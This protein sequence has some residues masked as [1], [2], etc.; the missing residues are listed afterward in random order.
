M[1]DESKAEFPGTL[2]PEAC[3][4]NVTLHGI[5]KSYPSWKRL[6]PAFM[7]SRSAARQASATLASQVIRYHEQLEETKKNPPNGGFS[8]GQ[9]LVIFRPVSACGEE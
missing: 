6:M 5:H 9:G 1:D 8:G 2:P 3:H 4:E 7:S